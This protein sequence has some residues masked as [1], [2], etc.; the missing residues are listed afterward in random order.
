MGLQVA[1]GR[2]TE[3][4][5]KNIVMFYFLKV[6]EN[7]FVFVTT[8]LYTLHI[9]IH[10]LIYIKEKDINMVYVNENICIANVISTIQII[11]A[12]F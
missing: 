3:D 9:F 2:G 12:F 6:M 10:I 11:F 7:V 5:F 4:P 8:C 1:T